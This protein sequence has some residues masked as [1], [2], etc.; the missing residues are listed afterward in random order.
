MHAAADEEIQRRAL[1]EDRIV[2]SADSDFGTLLARQEADR[3][4][5]ILFRETKLAGRAGL[6]EYAPSRLA[7]AGA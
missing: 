3:S 4:S 7:V 5:F 6:N 1:A 2:V